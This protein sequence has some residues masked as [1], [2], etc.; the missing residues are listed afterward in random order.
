MLMPMPMPI[1]GTG[2]DGEAMEDWDGEDITDHGGD[3]VGTGAGRR[4]PLTMKKLPPVPMLMLMLTLMHG[5]DITADHGD[6][7]V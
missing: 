1:T 3:M 7:E 5:T 2:E 6:M 4:G